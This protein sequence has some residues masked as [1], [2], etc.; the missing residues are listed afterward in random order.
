MSQAIQAPND[1]YQFLDC[2]RGFA[3]VMVII[4]HVGFHFFYLI[5][6][7]VTRFFMSIGWA[8]VDVFFAISGYLITK[9]LVNA[10]EKEDI[11]KFFIKRIFR[12][13]P[14][15]FV[16]IIFYFIFGYIVGEENISMLWL[17]ALFL[18]GWVIPFLGSEVVPYTITWSLS[19]EESAY[20][21]FGSIITLGRNKFTTLLKGLV[22]IS[23]ILRWVLVD[24]HIFQVQ[25]VYYFPLTRIDS[26]AFGGLVALNIIRRNDKAIFSFLTFLFVGLLYFWLSEVGQYN[27]S[28]AIFG[29]S[30]VA[31][32]SA[33]VVAYATTL[34]HS[35]NIFI[36]TL[37]HIGKRSYFIYLFHVFVIGAIGLPVFSGL[38][39]VLGFWGIVGSV[40]ILTVM[41]A[42]VSWRVFESPLIQYGRKFAHSI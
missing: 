27:R 18:T 8:G 39:M 35:E 38:H 3:I 2:L 22:V 37:T 41:M 26:I 5:D 14:I 29:Y 13:I 28:V 20:I 23:L 9:I 15:Y 4:H 16:A 34:K 40:V 1:Y 10:S 17:S 24:T 31:F 36:R 21:F 33:L 11:K 19:V 30:A 42:E 6:D 7:P 12:I 32:S 25:E